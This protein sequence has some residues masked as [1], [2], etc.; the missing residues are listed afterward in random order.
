M[1]KRAWL[2][3]VV[4]VLG[5]RYLVWPSLSRWLPK[6]SGM[7]AG[8]CNKG[9]LGFED[10]TPGATFTLGMSYSYPV[11]I[12][13]SGDG[14]ST[15]IVEI[16]LATGTKFFGSGEIV[17]I[18][19]HP[20]GSGQ[21]IRLNNTVLNFDLRRTTH[22]AEFEYL[23]QGGT[24]NLGARG[25]A[26]TYVGSMYAMPTSMVINGV[27]ITKSNVKYFLNS[28]GVKVAE[29][30]I[31]SLTYSGDIGGMII[32]GQEIHLDNFCFN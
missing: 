19:P 17:N 28:Q 3:S 16:T 21:M 8:R 1:K 15:N 22:K 32:G 20:F 25:A 6:L 23:D 4:A 27:R 5:I 31:V 24:I 12:Y 30:G 14:L 2:A 10:P 29:K 13:N 11:Q 9:A 7:V 18:S 26:N